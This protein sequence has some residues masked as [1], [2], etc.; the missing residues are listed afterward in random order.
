MI[1]G[2]DAE[3]VGNGLVKDDGPG[4]ELASELDADALDQLTASGARHVIDNISQTLIILATK[5]TGA[6]RMTITPSL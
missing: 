5:L 3:A 4:A 6:V 2:G 1:G